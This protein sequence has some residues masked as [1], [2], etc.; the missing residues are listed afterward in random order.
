MLRNEDPVLHRELGRDYPTAQGATGAYV[1]DAAGR[2]YLDAAGSYF[3]INIGHGVPE[4]VDAVGTRAKIM[5]DG[6]FCRG[7]DIVKALAM[8]AHLVGMGRMQ[9]YA[10]AAAGQAGIVRMLELMEDEVQRCL[11]L[12]GV[13]RYAELDRSYLTPAAPV[14]PPHVLSAFPHMAEEY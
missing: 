3:V 8:G 5:I 10:L 14:T 9:C 2:R 12:L 11:G 13:A 1:Y 6:S 7:T 4:V